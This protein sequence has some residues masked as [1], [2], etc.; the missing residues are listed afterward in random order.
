MKNLL[1]ITT[2]IIL[3]SLVATISSACS[4]LPTDIE[5]EYNR[6]DAVFAGTVVSINPSPETGGRDVL[7]QVSQTWKGPISGTI[8]VYTPTSE[9]E[10]G[11]SFSDGVEYI[12]FGNTT[13]ENGVLGQFT[14]LCTLT[15]PISQA[16]SILEW[17]SAVKNDQIPWGQIKAVFR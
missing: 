9:S 14:H 5:S 7:V 1:T 2:A 3:T 16:D 11:Y 12:I 10:C 13:M 8:H 6:S 15:T 17:L 4:C